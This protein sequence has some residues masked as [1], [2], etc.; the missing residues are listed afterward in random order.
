MIVDFKL[1]TRWRIIG[2]L[3]DSGLRQNGHREEKR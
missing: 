1:F 3:V 2:D